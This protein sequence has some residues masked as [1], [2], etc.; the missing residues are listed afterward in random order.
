M[1]CHCLNTAGCASELA[2]QSIFLKPPEDLSVHE[3]NASAVGL[4]RLFVD[5]WSQTCNVSN[6]NLI[7]TGKYIRDLWGPTCSSLFFTEEMQAVPV[8]S[9]ALNCHIFLLTPLPI[10][11][12]PFIPHSPYLPHSLHFLFP[13]I[14]ITLFSCFTLSFCP[15]WCASYPLS[16]FSCS[17]FQLSS[18]SACT[19]FP[20]LFCPFVLCAQAAHGFTLTNCVNESL[21]ERQELYDNNY[22]SHYQG[23]HC[24]FAHAQSAPSPF[25]GTKVSSLFSD[26]AEILMHAG[27]LYLSLS[28][29]LRALRFWLNPFVSVHP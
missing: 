5:V 8:I 25:K 3:R 26:I 15:L 4:V 20:S 16:L 6:R 17:L 2:P 22:C 28:F 12:S 14:C 7:L 19:V 10:I 29:L 27:R 1:G 23:G 9:S 24:R 13:F 21:A 11:S 18:Y